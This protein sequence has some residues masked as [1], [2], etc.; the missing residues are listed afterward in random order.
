MVTR[1]YRPSDIMA[2]GRRNTTFEYARLF[3]VCRAD[4]LLIYRLFADHVPKE[5][6]SLESN[7]V[8]RL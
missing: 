5:T 6:C 8:R 2:D 4:L 3:D 7:T 1:V